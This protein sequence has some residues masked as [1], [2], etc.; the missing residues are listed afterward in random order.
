MSNPVKPQ[1]PMTK[2]GQPFYPLTTIDQVL[3]SSGHRLSPDSTIQEYAHSKTNNIHNFVGTGAN[4]RAK[5]TAD[6]T[7]GDIF[8]VNGNT[9]TAYWGVDAPDADLIATGR[10]VTFIVDGDTI[11]F[12]PGGGLTSSKLAQATATES[13]VLDGDT[14]YAGDKNLKRGNIASKGAESVTLNAGTTSYTFGTAGK[15]CTG[16]MTVSVATKG[17]ES[18]TL[19]AS[20]TSKT[21]DTAGKLCT[22]N[23]TVSTT[24]KAA[25]SVALNASTTGYTFGTSGKLCTGNMSVSTSTMAGTSVTLNP[26]GSYTFATSGKL[27]TGNMTVNVNTVNTWPLRAYCPY[28][29]SSGSNVSNQTVYLPLPDG[30]GNYYIALYSADIQSTGDA[31]H[32][33]TFQGQ[34]WVNNSNNG[35]NYG[36]HP[37]FSYGVQTRTITSSN[38]TIT[39]SWRHYGT[40]LFVYCRYS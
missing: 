23:M 17:A 15:Y 8:A 27:C 3:D 10:W 30:D 33:L 36:V 18:V 20:T 13:D 24:T 26:G 38:R 11:N 4:G 7:E 34:V 39:Y 31:Y 32:Y 29:T 37:D 12:K 6:F 25:E 2:N 19:N 1:A 21:F 40:I 28:N 5:I 35:G 14:F 16:D 9:V 22:G